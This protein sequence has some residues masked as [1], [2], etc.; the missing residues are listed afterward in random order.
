MYL[1]NSIKKKN[2]KIPIDNWPA[3]VFLHTKVNCNIGDCWNMLKHVWDLLSYTLIA[4]HNRDEDWG[5]LKILWGL[6]QT[7]FFIF[8]K[9]VSFRLCEVP[10]TSRGQEQQLLQW[11]SRVVRVKEVAAFYDDT[12]FNIYLL[13]LLKSTLFLWLRQWSVS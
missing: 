9:E 10:S 12:S 13:A 1:K 3:K 5:S 2:I 6:T 4:D 8:S 11:K 7:I